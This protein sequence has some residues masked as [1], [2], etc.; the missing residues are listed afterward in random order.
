MYSDP[1]MKAALT[2][3]Q[4]LTESSA[5]GARLSIHD[6]ESL[7]SQR[8]A[9]LD[10]SHAGPSSSRSASLAATSASIAGTVRNLSHASAV[11][12]DKWQKIA[13][14]GALGA[15]AG[16]A[17]V[18]YDTLGRAHSRVRAPSTAGSDGSDQSTATTIAETH[19]AMVSPVRLSSLASMLIRDRS[20]KT[21]PISPKSR[22]RKASRLP[23][24][25]R[26]QR[27]V[28]SR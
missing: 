2:I 15:A 11:S 14:R 21:A 25:P 22:V 13:G 19:E 10:H 12:I 7:T 9:E 3:V 20:Q 27:T 8:L 28:L 18:G 23:T 1:R 26:R 24:D 6:H 4:S 17:F 16:N 5:G